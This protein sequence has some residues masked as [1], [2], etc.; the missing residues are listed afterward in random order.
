ML[1]A[2]V[3]LAAT[4]LQDSIRTWVW[5]G[6]YSSAE[7]VGMTGEPAERARLLV[8]YARLDAAFRELRCEGIIEIDWKRR[9]TND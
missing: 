6:C 2:V 4:S 3:V 1:A 8:G 5:S 9:G 7:V